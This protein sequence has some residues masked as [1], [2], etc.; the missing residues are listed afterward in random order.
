[1][2]RLV[3]IIAIAVLVFGCSHPQPCKQQTK[4]NRLPPQVEQAWQNALKQNTIAAYQEFLS[5]YSCND[6]LSKIANQKIDSLEQENQW[7]QVKNTNNLDSLRAFCLKYPY[8]VHHTEAYHRANHILQKQ[9]DNKYKVIPKF[10]SAMAQTSNPYKTFRQYTLPDF[11]L[12][13]VRQYEE[14]TPVSDTFPVR[15]EQAFDTLVNPNV[16]R[17]CNRLFTQGQVLKEYELQ[18]DSLN[19]KILFHLPCGDVK[20]N[21]VPYNNQIRLKCMEICQDFRM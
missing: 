20:L 7:Q 9:L 6:S 16:F 3:Y 5:K 19:F 21:W 17:E 15:D 10:L 12:I 2:N 1:M 11:Y 4:A 18:C 8:S 14:H 13:K